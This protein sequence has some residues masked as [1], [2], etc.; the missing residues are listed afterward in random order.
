MPRKNRLFTF[1]SFSE[2]KKKKKE[3]KLMEGI[4]APHCDQT[5]K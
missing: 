4:E 5:V 1:F 3:V 2:E